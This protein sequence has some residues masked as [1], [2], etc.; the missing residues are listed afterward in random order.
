VTV[1]ELIEKLKAMPP[2]ADV[3]YEDDTIPRDVTRVVFA[4][5]TSSWTNQ[6]GEVTLS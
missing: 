1:A 4:K 2:D 5:S 3:L 6:S